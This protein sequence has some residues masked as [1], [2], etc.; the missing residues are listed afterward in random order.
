[1]TATDSEVSSFFDTQQSYSCDDIQHS[2]ESSQSDTTGSINL[3]EVVEKVIFL[4]IS[5]LISIVRLNKYTIIEISTTMFYLV[6][7]PQKNNA[8]KNNPIYKL[9]HLISILL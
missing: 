1:L 2:Q 5:L 6:C 8:G 4:N 3:S 7:L 9:Y